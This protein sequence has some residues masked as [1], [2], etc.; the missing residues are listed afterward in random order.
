[1]FP[2]QVPL[3]EPHRERCSSP[4][5]FFYLSL[6]VPMKEP[7]PPS[8]PV[9]APTERDAHPQGLLYIS[10]R[11]PRKAATH[12]TPNWHPSGERCLSPGPSVHIFQIFQKRSPPPSGPLWREMPVTRVFYTHFSDFPVQEPP[13]RFPSHSAIQRD[14]PF[15]QHSS[16]S[17]SSST[18][19]KPPLLVP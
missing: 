15:P 17:L 9:V 2:L 7:T 19:K 10:F 6:K 16:T 11:F 14:A 3:T 12:P 1:M 5:A 18:G 8:P 4:R 13:Y